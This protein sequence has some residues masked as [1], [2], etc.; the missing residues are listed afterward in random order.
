MPQNRGH[1]LAAF[2]ETLLAREE[3]RCESERWPGPETL[4]S[5]GHL[6]YAM[7]EL[8]ERSTAVDVTWANQQLAAV[9][10]DPAEI[11]YL[12]S[13]ATLLGPVDISF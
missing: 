9:V 13:G 2:V 12:A 8:Y 6:A 10:P 1:L 11:L 7:Q 5:L 3:K 4:Y